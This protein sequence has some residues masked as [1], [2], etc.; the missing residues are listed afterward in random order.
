MCCQNAVVTIW[1]LLWLSVESYVLMSV[2]RF[3]D[4][5]KLPR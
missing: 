5:I 1:A 2:F 3:P 4:T